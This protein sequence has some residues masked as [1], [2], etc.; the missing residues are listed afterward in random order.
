[1]ELNVL[2][3]EIVGAAIEVRRV[4]NELSPKDNLRVSAPP[5]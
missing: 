4:I 5:C 2:T 1:M 3:G